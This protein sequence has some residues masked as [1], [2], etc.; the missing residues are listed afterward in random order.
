ME[1]GKLLDIENVNWDLPPL[2]PSSLAFLRSLPAAKPTRYYIGTPAWAHKEWLGKIYPVKT[3]PADFLS[4]YARSFN[5]I[6]LN[7]THYRIPTESQ[8][9]KWVAQVQESSG[10]L[11]CPKVYQGISHAPQGLADK[12]LFKQWW[13]F[14]EGL[15]DGRGPCFLQLPPH[16][17]YSHKALL[18]F[19]LENWPTEFELS[20]E[21]RHSSWFEG[22]Y[23]RPRLEHYLQHKKIGVV[24]TDVAGRRDLAHA[25]VTSPEVILRF[26]GNDLHPSDFTRVS[27]GRYAKTF[28]FCP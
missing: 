16:F 27:P 7:T 13:S 11:F 25:S 12:L 1:F 9:Q 23:L 5:S 4:A 17:D 18:F 14:L 15:R 3:K 24:I 19:F 28:L 22:R 20:L 26:I 21:F 2:A 10:F 6:E 8:V